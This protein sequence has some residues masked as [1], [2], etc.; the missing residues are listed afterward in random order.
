VIRIKLTSWVLGATLLIGALAVSEARAG[1]LVDTLPGSANSKTLNTTS[2]FVA[3]SF[4]GATQV[5]DV[6]L[7]VKVAGTNG[8]LVVTLWTDLGGGVGGLGVQPVT[9]LGTLAT[10]SEQAIKTA[11]GATNTKGLINITNLNNLPFAT[12]LTSANTYWIQVAIAGSPVSNL[13][14]FTGGSDLGTTSYYTN[15]LQGSPP[16]MQTC[17]SSD[18]SC[19]SEITATDGLTIAGTFATP[20]PEPGGLA[21]LAS[22]LVGLGLLRLRRAGTG[23]DAFSTPG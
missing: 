4:T 17:I 2:A 19:V 20:A 9:D 16:W 12:G 18:L 13:S 22:A 6:A 11:I 1:L 21:I 15:S 23:T 7:D 14:V 10:I 3:E 5:D 8:S